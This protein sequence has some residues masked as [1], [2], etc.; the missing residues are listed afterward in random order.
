MPTMKK[1]P[2]Y[3]DLQIR[4]VHY[5]SE[6]G[7]HERHLVLAHLKYNT[8]ALGVG[9]TE[10]TVFEAVRSVINENPTSACPAGIERFKAAF[11]EIFPPARKVK[12]LIE[13][14]VEDYTGRDGRITETV[15]YCLDGAQLI[16]GGVAA[17]GRIVGVKVGD[18]AVGS[19]WAKEDRTRKAG[20]LA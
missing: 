14:E 12:V 17:G 11:P 8:V 9:G 1:N 19:G 5:L 18:A 3:S 7:H 10:V 15:V 20:T 13:V 6:P 4:L 2:T 16:K